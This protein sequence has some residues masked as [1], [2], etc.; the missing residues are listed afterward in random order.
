ML[1][2]F[3]RVRI[4]STLWTTAHQAPLSMGFSRQEYWAATSSS[5]DLPDPG[6]EPRSLVSPALAGGFFTTEPPG[7]SKEHLSDAK[8]C[9]KLW[10]SGKK[11]SSLLLMEVQTEGAKHLCLWDKRTREGGSPLMRCSYHFCNVMG[12]KTNWV[13]VGKHSYIH[14][15]RGLIP[16]VGQIHLTKFTVH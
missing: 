10:R 4:F 16:A 12:K 7:K 6:I 1:S 8:R 13:G 14:Y 15:K 5:R 3:R 9:I 11:D 2:C